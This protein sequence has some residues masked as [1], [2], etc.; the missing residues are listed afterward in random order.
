MERK[1]AGIHVPWRERGQFLAAFDIPEL[2]VTCAVG[3]GDDPRIAR[4][5]RHIE[6]T[7]QE[8]IQCRGT[9]IAAGVP[10][11]DRAIIC[12]RREG[13]TSRAE[14]DVAD[15]VFIAAQCP[16]GW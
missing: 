15:R 10:K 8:A 13:I 11:L 7:A 6:Y 4:I 5:E 3:G 16:D 1:C 14:F 2:H 12:Q 9:G